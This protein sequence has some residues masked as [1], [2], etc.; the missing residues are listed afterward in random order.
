MCAKLDRQTI[1]DAWTSRFASTQ[2]GFWITLDTKHRVNLNDETRAHALR[3]HLIELPTKF[4]TV[5][6][7]LNEYCFGRRFLHDEPN[8]KLNCLLAIEV[9]NKSEQDDEKDDRKL[10]DGSIVHGHLVAL[11]SGNTNRSVDDVD[12]F[13]S[14]VVALLRLLGKRNRCGCRAH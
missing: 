7:Q 10:D 5:A 9:G 14:K 11:H 3:R 2:Q 8:A 4:Q 1:T 13:L 6:D 12:R